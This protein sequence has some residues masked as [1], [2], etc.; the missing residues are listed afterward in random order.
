MGGDYDA[1]VITAGHIGFGF[2]ATPNAMANMGSICEK[3]GYSK[4]G[5]GIE[6]LTLES[7]TV[8]YAV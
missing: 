1:A 5:E 6:I 2:A 8:A 4:M 7:L 3:Y